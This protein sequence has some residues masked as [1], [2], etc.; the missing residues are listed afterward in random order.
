MSLKLYG[1]DPLRMFE[2]VFNDKVSPFFS[3]MVAP[4]FKVDISEDENAIN[5][6]ADLPGVKKEDVKVS[7]DD[8]VLC[9][10]AERTQNEEEKKKGYHRIERSWGSLSRSFT[11]GENINADK[12]EA[13][14]D[15]GV[16]KIVLP[17]SEPKP[18]TGKEI[19]IK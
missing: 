7:M 5:I 14:Y 10:T 4:S 6:E 16:L 13:S 1:R 15:N 2:D 17:K 9:I 18:K 8:D 11:V 12:I 3:S 19:S